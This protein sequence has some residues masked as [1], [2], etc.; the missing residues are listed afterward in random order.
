MNLVGMKKVVL[1]KRAR[2]FLMRNITSNKLTAKNKVV[3]AG[4]YFTKIA[5]SLLSPFSVP[6]L[7]GDELEQWRAIGCSF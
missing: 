2:F 6:P 1:L 7:K 5:D 3:L 4:P